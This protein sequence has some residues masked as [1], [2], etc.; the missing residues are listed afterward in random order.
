M[1]KYEYKF[2]KAELK[3]GFDYSKKIAETEAESNELGKQGWRFCS[4]GD[5]AVIF[6]REIDNHAK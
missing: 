5:G 1:K 6:M 4:F 2:I 3:L